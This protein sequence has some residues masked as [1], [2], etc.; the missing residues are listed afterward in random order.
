MNDIYDNY[1]NPLQNY[2]FPTFKLKEKV[3]VGARIVKK[4]DT[5]KTPYQRLL[6]SDDVCSEK[7]EKI[8]SI[9]KQLNPFEL[10]KGLEAKL[11]H[12]FKVVVEFD[13]MKK[14]DK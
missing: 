14:R 11:D 3:R 1:W 8:R 5:P 7:K 12:F 4:Y 10:R 9:K 2:F 6:D 13:K